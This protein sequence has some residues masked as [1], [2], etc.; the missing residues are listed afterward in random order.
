MKQLSKPNVLLKYISLV[1]GLFLLCPCL[2]AH[3]LTLD[4]LMTVA[5]ENRAVVK[6]YRVEVQ[7]SL[8]QIKHA[9]GEFLPSF[10][11]GYRFNLLGENDLTLEEKENNTFYTK[12]SVNLFLG[13]KDVCSLASAKKVN[14]IKAFEL[15]G[16]SQDLKLDVGLCFLDV[17]YGMARLNV[18]EDAL[19]LYRKEYENVS[20]RYKMG[21]LKKNDQLK[22]KVVMD[23]ALQEVLRA[24]ATLSQTVNNLGLKTVGKISP[25]ALE[26]SCFN[27]LPTL[28]EPAYYRGALLENRSEINALTALCDDLEIR[29]RSARSSFYPRVD[30][31]S[32][33]KYYDECQDGSGD[34]TR[35]Q[36]NVSVN[37][38]DGF[39]K[40]ETLK[41]AMLDVDRA[42]FDLTELKAQLN[43]SL[44]NLVLDFDV[45][46][47]KLDVAR[48]SRKEALEHLR[49][50]QLAF[51]KGI[52]T[53][54]DILDAIYYLSRAK[55]NL[56]DSRVQIFRTHFHLLRMIEDL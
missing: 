44:K 42:S 13:F 50:T 7:K 18:A 9:K 52:L 25:E 48:N 20:L 26:F 24:R 38:F 23:N 49:I 47:K 30:I 6:A 19:S 34:E 10:D 1:W 46:M 16:I 3:G 2:S 43:N 8:H 39:Q 36:L 11:T 33:Y 37:L 45:S 53:S 12:A 17:Y 56:L 22:I 54:T 21:I 5:I 31:L 15:K 51:K 41:K 32:D 4:E 29:V 40:N 14:E 35:I 28:A 27:T 55:F